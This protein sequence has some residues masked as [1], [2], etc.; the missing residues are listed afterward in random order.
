[1][2]NSVWYNMQE[3]AGILNLKNIGRTKLMALLRNH[4][5]LNRHNQPD[6]SLVQEGYFAWNYKHYAGRY[7]KPESVI[8]PLASMRGIDL[9]RDIISNN[10][11]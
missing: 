11:E 8:V 3:A 9:I 10:H 2:S 4:S 7:G 5:I 6:A 1:M